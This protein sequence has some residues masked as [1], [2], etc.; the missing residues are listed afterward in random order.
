M[1]WRMIVRRIAFEGASNLGKKWWN[2]QGESSFM[3]ERMIIAPFATP[4]GYEV[5]YRGLET[6]GL[7]LL[8]GIPRPDVGCFP[9][10]GCLNLMSTRPTRKGL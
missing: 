4:T 3:M 5:V 6:S 10:V 7:I 2:Q 1:R 8:D 9:C